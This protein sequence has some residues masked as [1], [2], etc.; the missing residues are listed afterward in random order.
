MLFPVFV[1]PSLG[2]PLQGSGDPGTQLET[3]F[4]VPQTLKILSN[5]AEIPSISC[6]FHVSEASTGLLVRD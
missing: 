6:A 2:V 4:D 1:T 5:K 3:E